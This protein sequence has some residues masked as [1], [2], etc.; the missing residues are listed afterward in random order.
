MHPRLSELLHDAERARTELLAY[1]RGLSPEA[2]RES[3]PGGWSP[4]QVMAH[5]HLVE[6][7]SL[8]AMFR[9]LRT[10][11]NAGLAPETQDSSLLGALAATGLADGRTKR[12]AP[13]FVQ[14]VDAP[15]LESA[16]ARLTESRNGLRTWATEADGWD[17]T[18]VSF[19]HP[20]LGTLNLY[21]WVMMIADHERRH[22]RQMREARGESAA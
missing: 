2:Y 9:A 5:L 3:P 15:D 16:E 13:E 21:E 8:R 17:L 4:S 7:S 14:P 20:A 12:V 18:A 22:L 19:P 6:Q 1:V 10:A 11:R